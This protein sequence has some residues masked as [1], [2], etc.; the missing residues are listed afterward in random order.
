M[1][2]VLI[3]DSTLGL[4]VCKRE[5]IYH[6]NYNHEFV[7]ECLSALS[8]V[9]YAKRARYIVRNIVARIESGDDIS[10]EMCMERIIMG[11]VINYVNMLMKIVPCTRD[12]MRYIIQRMPMGELQSG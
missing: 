9:E 10:S 12:E 1:V 5:I 8:S 7:N 3:Q 4:V 2:N 6:S 11:N